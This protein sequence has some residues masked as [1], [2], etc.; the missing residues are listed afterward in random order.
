MTEEKEYVGRM[1]V[2]LVT[3]ENVQLTQDRFERLNKIQYNSVSLVK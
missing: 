2:Q 1:V 3:Q